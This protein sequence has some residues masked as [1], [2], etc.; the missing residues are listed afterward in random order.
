MS[1]NLS[2]R[3]LPEAV[4]TETG[5]LIAAGAGAYVA[6]GTPLENPSRLVL[7]QN[8]TD[9]DVMISFD[10]VT[11]HMPV[12]L[13]AFVLLDVTTNRSNTGGAF[14]VGEGTQFWARN[15]GGSYTDPTTGEF[16]ISSFYGA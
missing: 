15:L 2:V 16:F 13:G 9:G 3:I 7:F 8:G 1:S 14:N 10:G 4:L 5:A 12:F 11:D 6:I